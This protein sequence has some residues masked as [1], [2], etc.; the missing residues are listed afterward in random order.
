MSDGFVLWTIWLMLLGSLGYALYT[1]ACS[2]ETEPDAD[3]N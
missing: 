3:S 2:G 1:A